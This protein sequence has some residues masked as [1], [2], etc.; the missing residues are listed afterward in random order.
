MDKLE[1]EREQAIHLLRAG[2]GTQEVATQLGRSP[3]WVRKWRR[4][5]QEKGWAG[6]VSRSHAPHRHGKRISEEVRQEVK[7]TRS[8][9]EAEAERTI[10]LKY[11]GGTA[12]R[13]RLKELQ[14]E[15]LPSIRT[16]ERILREAK[17][18]HP[19]TSKPK[20]SYPRLR[21]KQPHAVCQ[22]DH[23]PR[24]LRGGEK[25]Y[26]FNAIDVV[27]RYPT[28]QAKDNRRA[29]TAA[30]FLVH[31]WQTIGIPIYTQVD[32]EACFIGGFT[33]P[34][35]LGQCVRLALMVGT[36][37]VFSPVRH[38]QSNAY[39][40]R[41]HQDYQKHVWEDTYLANQS[42]VQTQAEHFFELYRNSR[43]HSAL[44]GAAPAE[45]HSQPSQLLL[46]ANFSKPSGKLPL[47]TGRVHFMRRVDPDGTV[48][49]LN[50]K[51][52]LPEVDPSKGVWV[53]LDIKPQEATLAIYDQAPD[54]AERNVLAVYPFPISE[55]VLS[56]GAIPDQLAPH[57]IEK[58]SLPPVN[59]ATP[60]GDLPST[61]NTS[62]G[63]S[64]ALFIQAFLLHIRR[65]SRSVSE[66]F[67]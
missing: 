52:A 8:K 67:Y 50:V 60:S 9:L 33:H 27:S 30:D 64:A 35:V 37:L 62:S 3:Q 17:M 48:S 55:P 28:G 10:G 49:V 44:N 29:K 20:I 13:T 40:E 51:W 61:P 39:V 63:L 58:S 65:F 4:E 53:T 46:S 26:C 18:T 45:K 54:M 1:A 66:T 6:L 24:Y 7:K 16:I 2:L 56:H 47:Y 23:I 34:Y 31:V 59:T 5:F 42:A 38:P 25:V 21:P 11:I 15:P 57:H 32:N 12:I 43:H 19:K 22:V 36:E 14:I 41:F